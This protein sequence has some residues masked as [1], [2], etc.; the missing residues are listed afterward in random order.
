M[1]SA[2]GVLRTEGFPYALDN[3]A[4]T[5]FQKGEPFDGAAFERA[6]KLLGADAD[7]IVLFIALPAPTGSRGWWEVLGVP[8]GASREQIDTAYR[9]K[10]R[11]AHPDAGGDADTMAVLNAA[12][13]Q[14]LQGR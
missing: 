4:W 6:V 3:G 2:R 12:R 14:A 13:E 5:A 7:W 10:A 9:E 8:Q 11:T 1:V